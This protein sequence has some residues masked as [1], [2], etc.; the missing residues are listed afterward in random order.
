MHNF[1]GKLEMFDGLL[2]EIIPYADVELAAKDFTECENVILGG[3][4]VRHK[5]EMNEL[6]PLTAKSKIF[7]YELGV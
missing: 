2:L 3:A 5:P 4:L 6:V 1:D 7:T